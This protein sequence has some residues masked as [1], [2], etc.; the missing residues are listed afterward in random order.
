V[1]DFSARGVTVATVATVDHAIAALWNPDSLKRIKMFEVGLFKTTAGTAADSIYI[2]RITTQGTAG[3]VITPDAD[4]A[5]NGDDVPASG[6][7][8]NL[9]AFSVQPTRGAPG[10]FGWVAPTVAASGF[11]WPTPRGIWIPPGTGL[12]ICQ[13]VATIWPVSE[14]YFAWE[15]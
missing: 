9:A 13:R 6:A 3:S 11:V 14:V 4:S 7:L 8:L 1:S 2:T 10:L 5:W 12:A 15:E